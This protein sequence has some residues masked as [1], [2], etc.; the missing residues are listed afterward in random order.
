ML[1]RLHALVIGPGLGRDTMMQE[2]AGKII[3]EAKKRG[4]P[5]VVDAVCCTSFATF[6][7]IDQCS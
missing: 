3:V 4:M 6:Q 5:I 7:S 2:T 1:D